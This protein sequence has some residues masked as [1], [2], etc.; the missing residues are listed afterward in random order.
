MV[1]FPSLI[2]IGLFLTVVGSIFL[3]TRPVNSYVE[4]NAIFRY[5]YGFIIFSLF[6]SFYIL[7]YNDEVMAT[8]GSKGGP[9]DVTT[10]SIA[11]VPGCDYTPV[12]YKKNIEDSDLDRLENRSIPYDSYCNKLPPQWV[13]SLG[14][15][16]LNCHIDGNCYESLQPEDKTEKM[17]ELQSKFDENSSSIK[18]LKKS[19]NSLLKEYKKKESASLEAQYL[20][21]YARLQNL[22]SANSALKNEIEEL[23]KY[24][25]SRPVLGSTDA[26]LISGGVVVPLY[27]V[28]LAL[29]G[30]LVGMT[31]KTPEFQLHANEKYHQEF[32]EG[33]PYTKR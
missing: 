11:I 15:K 17:V 8:P 14:G 26:R 30:A 16:I 2:P 21:E 4:L 25:G 12:K 31:R 5:A 18:K 3:F 10:Y 13:L 20:S 23:K 22:K 1:F 19:T 6:F 24:T 9:D 29:L 7:V 28:I 33:R 32:D 27:F